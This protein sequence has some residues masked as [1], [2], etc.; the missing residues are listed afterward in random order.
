MP[1]PEQEPQIR[2]L[3]TGQWE[4]QAT[5]RGPWSYLDLCG[6]HLGV[7]VEQLNQGETSSIHHYHTLEEEHVIALQGKATLVFGD[8]EHRFAEGDHVWFRA[9]D[10]MAHHFINPF[11]EPFRFLVIGER[12]RGDVCIY[13]EHGVANIMALNS[14]WK[15]FDVRQRERLLQET[16][17]DG[18]PGD[19]DPG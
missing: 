14:G 6:E 17:A 11:A 9:G 12:K 16:V 3:N 10:E 2:N 4:E 19:T 8:R 18:T 7:R 15:Q 13:P 5:P 1:D